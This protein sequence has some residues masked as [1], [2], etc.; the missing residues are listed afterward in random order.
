M[1]TTDRN[2]LLNLYMLPSPD[3]LIH[4]D[5]RTWPHAAIL[6]YRFI[7]CMLLCIHSRGSHVHTRVLPNGPEPDQYAFI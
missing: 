2:S 6:Q 3:R 5:V 1:M 4:D 7:D